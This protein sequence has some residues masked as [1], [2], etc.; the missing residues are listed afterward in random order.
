MRTKISTAIAAAALLGLSV[1]LISC[2]FACGGGQ[3]TASSVALDEVGLTPTELLGKKI[4]F[5]TN[6]SE[7]R[8]MS[9]ATCHE[10]GNGFAGNN[11]SV[12]G[13][14]LGILGQ[15][16]LRNTPSAMYAQYATAFSVTADGPVGGQ[17]LDGRASN[18][19]EQAKAPFLSSAEMNNPHVQAVISKIAS[20]SYADLFKSVHGST[21][22]SN[23]VTA[24]DKVAESIAA[25]ESTSRFAPF[26]SKYDDVLAGTANFSLDE[27]RGKILFMDPKKGNCVSCHAVDANSTQSKDHLFTDFSYDNLGVPRNNAIPANRD[28]NFYDLGLCGPKRTEFGV[29]G[30]NQ[31]L[32]LCGA[33]KVP[34]LRNTAKKTAWMHNGYFKSLRDVVS[35]YV[36]RDTNPARWYPVVGG[37]VN[38]YDDLPSAYKANVNTTEVPYNRQVGDAPALTDAEVDL[39]VTFLKTL[40]DK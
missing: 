29:G 5:D 6:L 16:G 15:H 10:S 39:I 40:N 37:A 2:L 38:K 24:F 30:A 19:A 3:S 25:F 11:G 20:S 14:P 34:T 31:D 17:F 7:P 27:K 8:G 35:F 23:A 13:V 21:S 26:T 9:C 33:F 32:T 18:L 22:L 28:S 1:M 12:N 4:F 36:T